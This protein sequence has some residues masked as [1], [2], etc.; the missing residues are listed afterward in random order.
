MSLAGIM[1]GAAYI[2]L[3][4]NDAQAMQA[5]DRTKSSLKSF[6]SA[7][8]AAG[9]TLTL[10]A[11][12][13]SAMIDRYI[14]FS[15]TMLQ[16][17]AVSDA[18]GK[19]LAS[20]RKQAQDL[21]RTTAFTSTQVA[22]GMTELARM[23]FSA[24]EVSKAIRPAMNLVRSTGEE[25]WRLGEFS[26]YTAS[27]LR[28]FNLSAK[29]FGRVADVMAMAAN[30]SS[31]DIAD[32]GMSLKI[33]GPA[34]KAM[35]ASLEST[36]SLLM[37]LADTGIRGS[38]AGTMLRRVFQAIA[39]QSAEGK[40]AA[41]HL[42]DMGIALKTSTGKA[43]SARDIFVDLSKK[44]QA[45]SDIE[46]VNFTMDVFDLRGSAAALNLVEF[47]SKL[48]GFENDLKK[49]G[50]YAER[51]AKEMEVEFGGA[52]REMKSALM[53]LSNAFSEVWAK[54]LQ[55]F[56]FGITDATKSLE[57]FIKN[58]SVGL[59]V[60]T[61]FMVTV[62]GF[63]VALKTAFAVGKGVS[64]IYEPIRQLD[65]ALRG[66]REASAAE[67]A[68]KSQKAALLIENYK[69]SVAKRTDAE[70]AKLEV[71]AAMR[72]KSQALAT[73]AF[74]EQ[75]EK[76]KL[77]ALKERFA[78]EEANNKGVFGKGNT[79]EF[80][81]AA[82]AVA[83]QEKVLAKAV[84]AREKLAEQ[85][86]IL[87]QQ[88]IKRA[89]AETAATASQV[90]AGA[91]VSHLYGL[92]K[93]RS[94]ALTRLL[95]LKKNNALTDR[96]QTHLYA[97]LNKLKVKDIALSYQ[98]A[99]ASKTMALMKALA[100]K[101]NN[102]LT[103]SFKA[104]GAAIAANPI[105]AVLTAISLA[106]MAITYIIDKIDAAKSKA[107]QLAQ[108][109]IDK[110]KEKEE[111]GLAQRQAAKENMR[112]LTLLAE[113]SKRTTLTVDQMRE[114]ENII[115]DMDWAGASQW[116]KL[117]KT[118]KK[119][120]I[121]KDKME[122]LTNANAVKNAIADKENTIAK[123]K[124]EIDNISYENKISAVGERHGMGK[125][126]RV[127]R[128]NFNDEE[129]QKIA[130]WQ[131][132]LHKAQEELEKYKA[133]DMDAIM[134]L[135]KTQQERNEAYVQQLRATASELKNAKEEML[136]LDKEVADSGKTFT[137]KEIDAINAKYAA[138]S[139]YYKMVIENEKLLLKN[140]IQSGDKKEQDQINARL[141]NYKDMLKKVE[142]WRNE[143]EKIAL[144]KRDDK[145]KEYEAEKTRKASE[146]AEADKQWEWNRK[147]QKLQDKGQKSE[148]LL[149][150]KKEYDRLKNTLAEMTK[151]RDAMEYSF[152]SILS[153]D[154]IGMSANE[155][156][157]LGQKNQ[158]IYTAES[159][160]EELR[161]MMLAINEDMNKR[162]EPTTATV[163][164]WSAKDLHR[165]IGGVSSPEERTARNTEEMVKVMKQSNA[166]MDK[167]QDKYGV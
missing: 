141:T 13:L 107:L 140:A 148:A 55:P 133:L 88:I 43:R 104:L 124:K 68:A 62:G 155:Q 126:E 166:K 64:A 117:D 41:K 72:E 51:K 144:K 119:L 95:I 109:S 164:S 54:N 5:L 149:F 21:G 27:I 58:N 2:K 36:T 118:A 167:M 142:S 78:V 12:P 8:A 106:T 114:A 42:R 10:V 39:E 134:G 97:L 120:T 67:S 9:D 91:A 143:Q 138:Y 157:Q 151:K 92:E 6:A 59:G 108:I 79:P 112:G 83:D 130:D 116:A 93:Q 19:E 80:T 61:K 136:K 160:I 150:V 74:V 7:A 46:K 77:A 69:L 73:A 33:A 11:A 139:K 75:A 152:K 20:L 161:R 87:R 113:I 115:K 50:G 48:K 29:D 163:S 40:E 145:W 34:A 156:R 99:G 165:M 3:T 18:S 158:E 103:A 153:E 26:E 159:R 85:E 44:M 76:R 102:A 30:K 71:Q 32:L 38:E 105:G 65:A 4:M 137:Q 14:K 63:G 98:E 123:L 129:K 24:N 56:V 132:E 37:T 135:E 146:K 147:L 49:S 1:A 162:P 57:E 111:K 94:V 125:I 154:G 60:L 96:Q 84:K 52:V 128:T 47:S 122:E 17:K 131:M 90:A 35:G 22:Q 82:K 81:A 45:M 28:I 53:E 101:A 110:A 127:K 66:L 86:N 16:V 15:D 25:M 100:A 31:V 89:A 70:K 23:G 121:V